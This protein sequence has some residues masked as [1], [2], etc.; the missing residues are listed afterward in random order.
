MIDCS[1]V[2]AFSYEAHAKLIVEEE[3]DGKESVKEKVPFKE[4]EETLEMRLTH[5]EDSLARNGNTL[6]ARLAGKHVGNRR[7]HQYY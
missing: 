7:K 6:L 5:E 4:S 3:I 2:S 1:Y